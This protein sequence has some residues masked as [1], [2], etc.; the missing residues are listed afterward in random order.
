LSFPN[1]NSLGI[2]LKGNNVFAQNSLENLQ[3]Q[4]P[5]IYLMEMYILVYH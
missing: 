3:Y 2:F 4:V 1:F 5:K